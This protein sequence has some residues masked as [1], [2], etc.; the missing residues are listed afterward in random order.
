MLRLYHGTLQI[1]GIISWNITWL[2]Q[3]VPTIQVL[4]ED[5]FDVNRLKTGTTQFVDMCLTFGAD[6]STVE[7]IFTATD[8]A[9]ATN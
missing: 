6:G 9:F 3:M 4:R 7:D 1:L 5:K 2:V 8:E